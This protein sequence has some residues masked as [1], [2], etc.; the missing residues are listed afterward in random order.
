LGDKDQAFQWLNTAY[1]EREKALMG[2]KADYS[3]DPLR[4]DPATP[5][6]C[7]ESGCRNLIS[8][9]GQKVYWLTIFE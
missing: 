1:H 9:T 4:S 8:P 2:L 5:T 7:A 6:C 3:L